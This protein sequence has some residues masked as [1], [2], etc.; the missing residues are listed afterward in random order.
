MK[1]LRLTFSLARAKIISKMDGPQ[2]HF[3]EEVFTS[4]P[5]LKILPN[6]DSLIGCTSDPAG[7]GHTKKLKVKS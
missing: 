2:K 6:M 7:L 3:D 1:I 5:I 4:F